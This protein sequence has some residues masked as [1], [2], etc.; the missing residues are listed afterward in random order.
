MTRTTVRLPD[1]LLESAQRH[2][3]D[4][5]RTFTELLADALRYELRRAKAPMVVREPL[6]TYTGKGLRPGVNLNDSSELEDIM[7]DI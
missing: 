6:P 4:T 1:E 3:Q 5:G 7:E 2:A